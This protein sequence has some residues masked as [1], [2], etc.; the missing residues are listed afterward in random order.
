MTTTFRVAYQRDHL[1]SDPKGDD[2]RDCRI[3]PVPRRYPDNDAGEHNPNTCRE[4]REDVEV[5]RTTRLIVGVVTES[6]VLDPVSESADYGDGEHDPT[7]NL[8]RIVPAFDGLVQDAKSN[9]AQKS[10]VDPKANIASFFRAELRSGCLGNDNRDENRGH[11]SE[12]MRGVCQKCETPR[13]DSADD[14][15]G[16]NQR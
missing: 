9:Q 16:E 6:F 7:G 11:V 3:N 13:I 2:E 12:D 8:S 10:D 1:E 14:L 5:E 15:K 4:I